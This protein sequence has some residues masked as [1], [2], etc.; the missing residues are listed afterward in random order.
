MKGGLD[1]G[2]G[3]FRACFEV[4]PCLIAGGLQLLQLRLGFILFSLQCVDGFVVFDLRIGLGIVGLGLEQSDLCAQLLQ[5]C[6][7]LFFVRFSFVLH[8]ILRD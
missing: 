5:L 1:L 3:F 7:E 6:I 8:N 4:F 2:P